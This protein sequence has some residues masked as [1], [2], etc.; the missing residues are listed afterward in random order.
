MKGTILVV[1]DILDN[2]RVLFNF[3]SDEGL[4]V[5]IAQSGES[6]IERAHYAKPDLILL[7]VLIPDINGFEVC[8][9]LKNS[10]ETQH[11]PVIFMTTLADTANKIQGMELGATDYITKPI[12]H[13][14]VL[15]RVNTHL[16]LYQLQKQLSQQNTQLQKEIH[17]RELAE[18]QLVEQNQKLQ[19]EINTRRQI[20]SYL[21]KV[22]RDLVLKNIELQEEI[23]FRKEIQQSLQGSNNS[24]HKESESRRKTQCSSKDKCFTV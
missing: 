8:K 16:N 15:A 22:K 10:P 7:D 5:L 11:I 12:Q 14:E 18:K 4:D 13:K 23:E 19:E 2:L 20:Q 21:E 6:G 1:D 17:K 9:I 24:L 3:L